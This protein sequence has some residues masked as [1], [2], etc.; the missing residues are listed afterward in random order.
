MPIVPGFDQAMVRM[1]PDGGLEIRVGVHSH[2][3]GM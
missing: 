2:G 3:Q 1:T